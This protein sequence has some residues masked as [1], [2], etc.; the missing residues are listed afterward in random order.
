MLSRFSWVLS[1]VA[2][3]WASPV[4]AAAF[5]AEDF[6][7]A[8]ARDSVVEELEN[9]ISLVQGGFGNKKSLSSLR[10]RLSEE[11]RRVDGMLSALK[12]L[13]LK[14][15]NRKNV[16][17]QDGKGRTLLMHAARLGNGGAIDLLL[18][19]NADV[20]IEDRDG[21]TALEYDREEGA[22]LLASRL[23]AVVDAAIYRNDASTVKMYC[24]AGLA[25][26]TLLPGGPLAGRLLEANLCPLA[27]ELLRGANIKNEP[28]RD[29]TLLT[30]LM[31]RCN[32]AEVLQRGAEIFGKEL[33]ETSPG[34]MDSLLYILSRG[35]LQAVQ[36]YVHHHGA[37]PHL[38]TLAV[39][40]SSPEVISWVLQKAGIAEKSGFSG[41]FPLF[42][43]ARRG[44]TAVY[45]AVS[46]V[47]GDCSARNENGETVLMHA[48]LSGSVELVNAVLQ[49]M[50]AELVGVSDAAGRT[51]LDY[52]RMSGNAMVESVLVTRGVQPGNKQ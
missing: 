33:W 13:A 44:N 19:G 21:R 14:A 7:S 35:N 2:L 25:A 36:Y 22:G 40:H 16:N 30:E 12:P 47:G 37:T 32:N 42:E 39:R 50:S 11:K 51:A 18:E 9:S 3:L 52:A 43:A 46:A 24:D 1:G 4:P 38:C 29:G 6:L 8:I 20:G 17:V 34:G 45:A 49:H 31:V 41:S 26:D 28:M 15:Q 27:A 10:R 48:A 23:A 5:S